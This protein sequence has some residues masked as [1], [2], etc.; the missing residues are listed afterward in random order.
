MNWGNLYLTLHV[1]WTLV[2]QAYPS[3]RQRP[4]WKTSVNI[5]LTTINII[6]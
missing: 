2:C 4:E 3:V 1:L 6:N 5:K